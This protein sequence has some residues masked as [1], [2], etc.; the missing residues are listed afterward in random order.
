M[1][2]S[3]HVSLRPVD[4]KAPSHFAIIGLIES[5]LKFPTNTKVKPL[6]SENLSL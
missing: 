3:R 2:V 1:P 5:A 6:A 4:G